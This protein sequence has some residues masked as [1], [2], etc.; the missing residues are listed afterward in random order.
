MHTHLNR[1]KQHLVA[2]F[3]ITGD[4]FK[5][6]FEGH[7]FELSRDELRVLDSIAGYCESCNAQI[8]ALEQDLREQRKA[9]ER[10]LAAGRVRVV[11]RPGEFKAG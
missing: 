7:T 5:E 3:R 9:T 8:A 6:D 2:R 4:G 11:R 10:D 1:R